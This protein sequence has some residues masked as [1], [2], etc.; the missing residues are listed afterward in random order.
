MAP[1]NEPS[2]TIAAV[3][4]EKTA[5]GPS[6]RHHPELKETI[7]HD[8]LADSKIVDRQN[9]TLKTT[10][11]MLPS[12]LAEGI[13]ADAEDVPEAPVDRADMSA[14][15]L[16]YY[17][18]GATT[19]EKQ[20][21]KRILARIKADPVVFREAVTEGRDTAAPVSRSAA[22]LAAEK[23]STKSSQERLMSD[24]SYVVVIENPLGHRSAFTIIVKADNSARADEIVDRAKGALR[25][26][27]DHANTNSSHG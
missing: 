6:D 21:A 5:C 20:L 1:Y 26:V 7:D 4:V 22:V 17:K 13:T 10:I 14:E 15:Q 24:Y 16:A 8:R 9:P 19:E 2:P 3:L 23:K 25:M 11:P 12:M 27:V 18:I